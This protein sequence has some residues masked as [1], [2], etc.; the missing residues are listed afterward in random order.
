LGLTWLAAKMHPNRFTSLSMDKETRGFY[1]DLYGMDDAAYDKSVKPFL[2][3][4]LP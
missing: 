1:R 3:G 4:N 2:T